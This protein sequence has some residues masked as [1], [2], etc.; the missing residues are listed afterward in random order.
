[1]KKTLI[2]ALLA[3]VAMAGQAKVKTVVWENPTTEYGTSYRDG[4]FELSL[5]V[6]KVELKETETL[7]Y[8]TVSQRSDYSKY[9]YQFSGKTFL[10]AGNTQYF[11]ISADGTELDKHCQTGKDGKADVV[12]HF[13]P[14]PQNTKVFDFSEG[15]FDGAWQIQGIKPV[16]ERWQQLFPSYWRD[17]KGDWKIAFF[18]NC[19][20]YD[21]QFWNYR[22]SN[23]NPKT[24]QAEM[25][26]TNGKEELKVSIG[27]DRKGFRTMQ[28]GNRKVVY[29]M[30]TSRF[31]PDYPT[32]DTRTGFTDTR[33][34]TDTVTFVGWLKDMPEDMRQLGKE[35]QVS[36]YDRIFTND[37]NPNISYGKMDDL[38][39]FVMKIPML[40]S[41]EVFYDWDRTYIR[42]LFEPGKTYFMLYDFKEG[43][44]Y[45]MG[46]DCR[47]QNETLA[48]PISW[49]FRHPD[50]RD[51]DKEKALAF[52]QGLKED[53]AEALSRLEK[54]I[55]VRPNVSDRYINYLKGHYQ[56]DVC[57]NLMQG[58]FYMKDRKVPAEILDYANQHWQ[59]LQQPYTL[60]REFKT[61][62]RDYLDQLV[63]NKY[64]VNHVMAFC[65][66][67]SSTLRKYRAAGKVKIT[68]EELDLV[69]RYA[70]G[71]SKYS[72]Y[73][74]D[75]EEAE[76]AS[77]EFFKSD[78]CKQ[79][80]LLYDREDIEQALTEEYPLYW[81][82]TQLSILDSIG[83]DQDL[84]DIIIA[85]GLDKIMDDT[86]E[87][88]S[89]H[90]M[91]FLEENVKM[92]AAKAY[93]KATHEKYQAIMSRDISKSPSLKS[94]GDVA[95]M[96]DGEQILRKLIAPYKGKIILLD[97]WGTWCGPCKEGLKHSQEEY[98][99][100][101][102]YD[103]VYLYLA[104]GSPDETWKN[105][106]KEYEVLGDN[107]VH[108][109]LPQDQQQAI[110]HFIG[111]SGYPTY[112]LID[113]DG[114]VLDVNADPRHDL[115]GLAKLLDKMNA[116][117]D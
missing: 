25:I 93:V 81:L 44:R 99:R 82:Y 52:M 89:D 17:D 91:E 36:A 111:I 79:F 24:G 7:V 103:L 109:N 88:L 71:F 64:L 26:L 117:K 23:V 57:R 35:Y 19:A 85:N 69:D 38:G 33:Y 74:A 49:G 29:S 1:M 115:D 98:E 108:Y 100:L 75:D 55:A 18:E 2:I 78:L 41:S 62:R 95:D 4:F 112:R 10:K 105:I 113:G 86:R 116:R 101:K 14:L 68:D 34:Q 16:E 12:L 67:Y 39:R 65:K 50:E 58:R 13:Q 11:I 30:I 96:S 28:I 56:M 80:G 21:C 70:D 3:L 47:L 61:F 94:A 48:H 72:S 20:I 15:D 22:Q 114:N 77:N 63:E 54:V 9:W 31:M 106:I 53:E 92:P 37:G 84:R 107:V 51:M 6:T 40:N 43:R 83:C 66:L 32:K 102:D 87:P 104:N 45:F 27:K 5:D 59:Q 97:I 8:M 42:T 110:E 46:D 76:K 73:R 60:Y 90:V